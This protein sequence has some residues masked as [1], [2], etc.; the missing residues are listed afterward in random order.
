M[1]AHQLPDKVEAAYRRGTA[2]KKRALLMLAWANYCEG[3]ALADNVLH[4]WLTAGLGPKAV[5]GTVYPSSLASS[6]WSM[7]AVPPEADIR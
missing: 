2:L 3:A 7:S 6:G 4:V 1:L 5:D